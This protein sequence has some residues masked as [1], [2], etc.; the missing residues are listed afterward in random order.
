MEKKKITQKEWDKY[1][2]HWKTIINHVFRAENA[3]SKECKEKLNQA[4]GKSPDEVKKACDE[5]IGAVADKILGYT[6]EVE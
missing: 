6:F 4:R 3:L 2:G 1:R 5:Y